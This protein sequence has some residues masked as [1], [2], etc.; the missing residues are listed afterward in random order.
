[1]YIPLHR[2]YIGLIYGTY[3]H[4]RILKWPLILRVSQAQLEIFPNEPIHWSFI[5]KHNVMTWEPFLWV[6][7]VVS[8]RSPGGDRTTEDV[9]PESLGNS[10]NSTKFAV[11]CPG[12]WM[13]TQTSW[14]RRQK[15]QH[16]ADFWVFHR[17]VR[18]HVHQCLFSRSFLLVGS[19]RKKWST[20][21]PLSWSHT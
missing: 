13:L 3:L 11:R 15:P 12:A 20:L 17:P 14:R 6:W 16:P 18:Y 19:C 4:F 7:K 8:W 9:A 10:E 2:H 1:M 21:C 5:S